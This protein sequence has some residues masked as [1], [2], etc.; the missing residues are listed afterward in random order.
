MSV[1]HPCVHPSTSSR[2]GRYHVSHVFHVSHVS[3]MPCRDTWLAILK[4][5]MPVDLYRKV[6]IKMPEM[7][8]PAAPNPLLLADF[9]SASVDQGDIR[10]R[11]QICQQRALSPSDR[12]SVL[13]T[14]KVTTRVVVKPNDKVPIESNHHG[15]DQR[16]CQVCRLYF[17]LTPH[18]RQTQFPRDSIATLSTIL[19]A[20]HTAVETVNV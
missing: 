13:L 5:R 14:L 15:N 17:A 16:L 7:I 18:T 20:S 9:L 4:L 8:I 6:L 3:L 10:P 1:N 19:D 2:D 12:I 11:C